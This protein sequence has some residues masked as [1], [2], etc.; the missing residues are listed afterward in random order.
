MIWSSLNS[1]QAQFWLS[2]TNW[3]A[4]FALALADSVVIILNGLETSLPVCLVPY[5]FVHISLELKDKVM[6]WFNQ[7]K[8]L[9]TSL[10][11]D[12]RW[13]NQGEGWA[14]HLLKQNVEQW[15]SCAAM[16]SIFVSEAVSFL[17]CPSGFTVPANVWDS[18]LNNVSLM[19]IRSLKLMEVFLVFITFEAVSTNKYDS[20]LIHNT[21]TVFSTGKGCN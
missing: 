13:S 6:H 2:S 11:G 20:L 5:F 4:T 8:L 17:Y 19:A 21:M 9:T 1:S 10:T 14:L 16:I 18:M 3:S 7:R 12:H 15:N